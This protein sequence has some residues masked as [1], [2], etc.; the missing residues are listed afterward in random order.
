N[1]GVQ[2]RPN[3]PVEGVIIDG[4]RATGVTT[5]DGPIH[6]PVIVNAAGPWS[7]LLAG[8]A[9]TVLP[10]AALQHH[11]LTT[12]P[13][14]THPVD[15]LSPAIRDRH[16]RLYARPESG[17]LIIGVYGE[18]T[19]EY[20]MDRL[21][22][23]FDMSA[24]KAKR[25]DIH[26]AMLIHAAS[27]RYPWINKRTPMSITT[28]IMTFTPDGKPFCGKLPDLEGFYHCSGFC[29]HGIVQSP[30][31]GVIMS[32]L[33]R[34]GQTGYDIAAI[35]ADRYFDVPG[36]QKRDEIKARCYEMQA[37]YYG[38]VEGRKQ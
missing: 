28:G 38:Q 34:N 5:P 16:L 35:E 31:I 2:Y 7:Y 4:G 8:L 6:A 21:P 22:V 17:G 24:M 10:T 33:I 23:D 15:R 1:H 19:V 36:F 11:Y 25:D 30:T 14:D 13:D 12:R 9:D 3:C 26:V 37:G 18:E 29:G 20:D 27:Q 32:E